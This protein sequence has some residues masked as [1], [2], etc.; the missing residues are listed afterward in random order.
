MA[1]FTFHEVDNPSCDA[2]YMPPSRCE[3][4]GLMHTQFD[5]DLTAIE[6]KCD[7]CDR[8]LHQDLEE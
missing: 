3:C 1:W 6:G 7:R 2:C 8:G 4:G 5:E